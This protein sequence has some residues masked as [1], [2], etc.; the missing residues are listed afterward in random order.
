M[1]ARS[2]ESGVDRR[3]KRAPREFV[4]LVHGIAD[5]G[6]RLQVEGHGYGRELSEVIH[7]QRPKR[8]GQFRDGAQGHEL[9]RLFERTYN[10]DRAFASR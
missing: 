4:D 10:D 3:R 8:A 5:R 6:A 1:P 9:R 2:L 7:R